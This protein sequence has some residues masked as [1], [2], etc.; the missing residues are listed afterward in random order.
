MLAAW[1]RTAD[2]IVASVRNVSPQVNDWKNVVHLPGRACAV[3]TV[4][5]GT[6]DNLPVKRTRQ[7]GDNEKM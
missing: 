7:I 6:G 4:K 1:L 3:T 2:P 5:Y